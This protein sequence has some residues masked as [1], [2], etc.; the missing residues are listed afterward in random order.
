MQDAN[1]SALFCEGP[2]AS[3][4]QHYC[5]CQRWMEAWIR[6]AFQ[7]SASRGELFAFEHGIC[8]TCGIDAHALDQRPFGLTPPE[9]FRALLGTRFR[10]TGAVLTAPK[11][12]HFRQA[13][14][15]LTVAEG[16]GQCPLAN[17]R[18]LCTPCHSAEN[19]KL[20]GMRM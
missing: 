11:E 16:G 7:S 3:L 13:D 2:E 17:S 9:R 12:G 8:R 1:S 6:G 10:A 5:S 15:I 19:Q 14:H 18:T 20:R 4:V